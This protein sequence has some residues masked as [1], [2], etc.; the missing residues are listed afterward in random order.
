MNV[1]KEISFPTATM[2]PAYGARTAGSFHIYSV[3]CI[4]LQ[5]TCGKDRGWMT[6]AVCTNTYHI[7][8]KFI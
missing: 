3:Y 4:Y 2:Q 5:V 8:Q 1:F 7:V 6:L